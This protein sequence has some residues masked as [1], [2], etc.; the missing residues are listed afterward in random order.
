MQSFV[1]NVHSG[2]Y[3]LNCIPVSAP[4]IPDTFVKKYLYIWNALPIQSDSNW[5]QAFYTFINKVHF[6]ILVRWM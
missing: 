3:Y 1:R 5:L 2:N 4:A 6:S